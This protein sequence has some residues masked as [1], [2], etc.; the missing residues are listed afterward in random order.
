MS[1]PES[2]EKNFAAPSDSASLQ[3]RRNRLTKSTVE[4]VET[5][6]TELDSVLMAAARQAAM[7]IPATPGGVSC[8]MKCGRTAS[9][10]MPSGSS[11]G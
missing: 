6:L 10:G 4:T 7:M 8:R 2:H 5:A 3:S 9:A 1:A 11:F